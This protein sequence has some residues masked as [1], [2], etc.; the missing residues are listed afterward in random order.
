MNYYGK[1]INGKDDCREMGPLHHI[2]QGNYQEIEV[3]ESSGKL[4]LSA[5][6]DSSFFFIEKER[7][8]YNDYDL[9]EDWES[10]VEEVI[11]FSNAREE[12]SLY[13]VEDT[14][15]VNSYML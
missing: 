14:F 6:E 3:K 2:T 9:V 1:F 8:V 5:S 13:K 4:I 11:C 7:K 10:E 15:Y 12:I